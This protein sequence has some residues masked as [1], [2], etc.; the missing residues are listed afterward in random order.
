MPSF[1]AGV[2]IVS[3]SVAVTDRQGR[4]VPRLGASDLALFD[5]GVRQEISLFAQEEWPIR[6]SILLDGSGSMQQALPVVKRAAEQL[7]RTLQPRDE[8]QVA[9]FTRSLDVLQAPTADKDALVRAIAGIEAGGQTAL[10]NALYVTLKDLGREPGRELAR[11]AVV[12]LTDGEDTASMVSDEQLLE[13][14]RRA[15]VVVYTIGMLPAA[16]AA[17]PDGPRCRPTCSR[18]SRVRREGAPIFRARPAS[19]TA[20]TTASRASCAHSTAWATCRTARA[21]TA[22]ST[23]SWFRRAS[24][25]CSCA[26]APATMRR[27]AARLSLR[28][29]ASLVGEQPGDE[30]LRDLRRHAS[31][32]P[33]RV[34]PGVELHHVGAHELAL[35]PLQHAEHVARAEAAGL[36]VRHAGRKGRVEPVEVHRDVDRVRRPARTRSGRKS[37][38]ST[39]STPKRATCAAAA[40]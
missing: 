3:L 21:R 17:A 38:I 14:A 33:G 32:G 5:D 6:L 13:L 12:V 23:G 37:F 26:T 28:P 1:P 34:A 36:G 25:T 16:S 22:P 29:A 24:P 10:Y 2:E 18:R 19:S 39:S 35:E 7:V 15:G 8:V 9:R 11:R 20:S 27:R 40:R 31:R 4:P 30:L